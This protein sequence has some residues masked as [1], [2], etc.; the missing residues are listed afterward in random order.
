MLPDSALLQ[1]FTSLGPPAQQTNHVTL[2]LNLY[3]TLKLI[4]FKRACSA[5]P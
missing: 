1:L 2:T 5:T 3:T 4:L